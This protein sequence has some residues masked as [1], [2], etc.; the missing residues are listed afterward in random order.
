[1]TMTLQHTVSHS[2]PPSKTPEGWT[3]WL[4]AHPKTT[5]EIQALIDHLA[6][7]DITAAQALADATGHAG[8]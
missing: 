6:I 3:R 4:A 2:S 5:A 7:R 1:M 8:R